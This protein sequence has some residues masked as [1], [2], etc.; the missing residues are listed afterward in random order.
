M[1]VVH[2]IGSLGVGGAERML[3]RLCVRH[4]QDGRSDP[5]VVS[6][7][8]AGPIGV[9]LRAQGIETHALGAEGPAAALVALARLVPLLRRLRPDIVQTWLYHADLIGGI[10]ARLSGRG[11]LVWNLRCSDPGANPRTRALVRV[12]AVL[13]RALPDAILCCGEEARR[14]HVALGYDPRRMTVL[15]NGFEV[16]HFQPVSGRHSGGHRFVAIG[17]DDP[18]K[19]FA[20]FVE[21]AGIVAARDPA[22]RFVLL[23]RGVADNPDYRRRIAALGLVDRFTLG[24]QVDDVRQP[25]AEADIFCSTSR[26]EGFPNVLCE[27]MLMGV[28]CVATDAGDSALIV[29]DTGRIVREAGAATFAEA[30]LALSRDVARDRAA[31][32]AAARQRIVAHFEIGAVAERY[33]GFYDALLRDG[34]R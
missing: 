8:D 19:N 18:L 29:G 24:D 6:L 3:E 16:G 4:R 33:A 20:L 21:A 9:R 26:H 32:A 30:M 5:C 7:T 25:L 10:A 11:K 1:R 13:S 34:G 27:A 17:R 14:A 2:V 22:A 15:P 12:N 23:G 28:P 31:M